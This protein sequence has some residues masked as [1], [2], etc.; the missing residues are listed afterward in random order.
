MMCPETA[1]IRIFWE[2]PQ[3]VLI[4]KAQDLTLK[5]RP[6]DDLNFDPQNAQISTLITMLWQGPWRDVPRNSQ[7]R[8]STSIPKFLLIFKAHH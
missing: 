3:H 1:T 8:T 7:D 4:F 5:N 6:F 2:D